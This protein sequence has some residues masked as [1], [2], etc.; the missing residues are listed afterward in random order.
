MTITIDLNI[1]RRVPDAT[2][3]F[4]R[5]LAG[6]ILVK[7]VEEVAV[8]VEEEDNDLE[9]AYITT[10][11]LTAGVALSDAHQQGENCGP[12]HVALLA[13][14]S[15][16]PNSMVA[17]EVITNLVT[18]ACTYLDSEEVADMVSQIVREEL[19]DD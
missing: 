18:V 6:D 14:M 3:L 17:S 4:L 7:R 5:Y 11:L 19:D 16:I 13:M 12:H 10:G 2:R 15:Q 9:A 1:L 8:E